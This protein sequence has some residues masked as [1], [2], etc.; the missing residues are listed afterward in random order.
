MCPLTIAT[1]IPTFNEGNRAFDFL[2]D[3]ARSGVDHGSVRAVAIL[4]DD[5]SREC[6]AAR[7]R[8]AV[9][10]ASDFLR[11]CAA[12]HEVRYVKADTNR[13]KGA[14]I[15]LGWSQAPPDAD[16]LSFVDADG[17]FPAREYWRLADALQG[18]K[19]DA[20][21]ASRAKTAGHTVERSLLREWQGRTFAAAVE[22]LFHFGLRDTQAGLKFFNASHLRPLL[23]SLQEDRWLL[24]IEVLARMRAAGARLAEEPVDCHM[25]VGSS[26]VFGLDPILMLTQLVSLRRRLPAAASTA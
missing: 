3:W 15:R 6:D 13:G 4:V 7:Q 25:R 5:G 11:R 18:A 10:A 20:V 16:W 23:S 22:A 17:A 26:L 24:D 12:A 8:E 21:C 14:A 1:V 9:T 2:Q 19:T